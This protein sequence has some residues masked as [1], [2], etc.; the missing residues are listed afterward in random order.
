MEVKNFKC[1]LAIPNKRGATTP[2]KPINPYH[3][4]KRLYKFNQQSLEF[5]F[6]FNEWVMP[7]MVK[8]FEVS[9]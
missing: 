2:I 8:D 4:F 3:E 1:Y 5:L 7:A 6:L 9:S